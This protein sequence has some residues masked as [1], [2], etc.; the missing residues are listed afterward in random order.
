MKGLT[1]KEIE[2]EV[3]T[4]LLWFT[5]ILSII[6]VIFT[7]VRPYTFAISNYDVSFSIFIFPFTILMSNYI[8]KKIGYKNSFIAI[9]I[10]S[11]IVL[12]F[13][14]LTDDII[15]KQIDYVL[16]LSQ[17]ISFFVS[18]FVNLAVYYY[19]LINLEK[20]KSIILIYFSYLFS[21]LIN[22]IIYMFFMISISDYFWELYFT[23][24][25]IQAIISVILVMFDIRIERGI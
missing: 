1:E 6:A 19:I 13:L 20:E 8:T 16:V 12:L 24:I 7:A 14:I 10:S 25:I 11:L 23:S 22:F 21:I 3:N 17:S 18:L 2:K 5:F 9:L 15:G 4:D